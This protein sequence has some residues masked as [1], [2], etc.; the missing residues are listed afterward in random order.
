MPKL[1]CKPGNY[2]CG[3]ICQSQKRRCL[4]TPS[5]AVA[6]D[7]D[8]FFQLVSDSVQSEIRG[9]AKVRAEGKVTKGLAKQ[10]ILE[11]GGDAELLAKRLTRHIDY[12]RARKE[13]LDPGTGDSFNQ[14]ISDQAELQFLTS[15]FGEAEALSFMEQKSASKPEQVAMQELKEPIDFT[16][17]VS[18]LHAIGSGQ[19]KLTE[20]E[21]DLTAL[22]AMTF[23]GYK[24]MATSSSSWDINKKANIEAGSDAGQEPITPAESSALAAYL[25][26]AFY[27]MNK[28]LWDTSKPPRDGIMATN[29]L[30]ASALAKLPR[31]SKAN[32][33]K[34]I[35]D[36]IAEGKVKYK[37]S[38]KYNGQDTFNRFMTLPVKGVEAFAEKY[39]EGEIIAEEVFLATTHLDEKAEGMKSFARNANVQY[40]IK[41]KLDGTGNGR[42]VDHF[43]TKMK[44]GE[45]LFPPGTRFKVNKVFNGK[46]L[47]KQR[48]DA[49]AAKTFDFTKTFL[50]TFT[51]LPEA[52]KNDFF[53]EELKAEVISALESG[54]DPHKAIAKAKDIVDAK[55]D[56]DPTFAKTIGGKKELMFIPFELGPL[57]PA[58]DDGLGVSST[59]AKDRLIIELE[60]V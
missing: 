10:F 35:E 33:A 8:K 54:D 55:F 23:G 57:M 45:L 19:H 52:I 24:D 34:I 29:Q 5:N 39:K 16:D 15:R 50:H 43:K 44:E 2:Q 42:Y 38:E 6:E 3:S 36:R 1:K 26:G 7:F 12:W 41:P 17:P 30:A 28:P 48:V 13:G 37:K 46:D 25:N 21:T 9:G 40:K 11:T 32:I 59:K 27:D 47:P 49:K 60:E 31:A 18:V 22:T 56:S 14:A 51:G 20:D 58:L 53:D 4:V